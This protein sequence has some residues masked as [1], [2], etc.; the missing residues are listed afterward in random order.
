MTRLL[1][2]LKLSLAY[3]AWRDSFIRKLISTIWLFIEERLYAVLDA[4]ARKS[5]IFSLL[6]KLAKKISLVIALGIVLICIIPDR[7]WSNKFIYLM[8]FGLMLLNIY[9]KDQKRRVA[10]EDFFVLF[11]VSI[12][13]SAG[14]SVFPRLSLKYLVNYLAVFMI[15]AIFVNNIKRE[16]LAVLL[17]GVTLAVLVVSLFGLV[18]KYIIG[19]AV[20]LSQTDISISQDLS[21]RVYSTMGNPNVLGELYILLIPLIVANLLSTK[22]VFVKAISLVTILI[23]VLVLLLT[24]SRSAWASIALSAV[25]FLLLYR[26]RVVPIFIMLGLI[27]FFFMPQNIQTRV[28]SMFNKSDTSLNYRKYIRESAS[29]MKHRYEFVGGVGLGNEVFQSVF[30]PYKVKELTK[31]SHSH[32]L[33]M[34]LTIE[35]GIFAVFFLLA[36]LAK[37]ILH[38]LIIAKASTD[39]TQRLIIYACISAILGF[40]LMSTA[41]YTWFYLRIL[42]LFFITAGTLKVAASEREESLQ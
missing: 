6:K 34:Q 22:K 32:S 41:D 31:V 3:N 2:N 33:Y 24:G 40:M 19:I 12:L 42:V 27:S 10:F 37:L 18:Q 38:S 36:Y 17:N 35:L 1:E 16:G 5:C 20:N 39:E 21:G 4:L 23:S 7:F 11:V 9:N 13:L 25:V 26:P 15:F 30:E 29:D 8:A 28:V 14:L